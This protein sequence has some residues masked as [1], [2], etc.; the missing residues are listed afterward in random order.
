MIRRLD[1]QELGTVAALW[2]DTNLR[3][4]RFI[5]PSYWTGQFDSVRARL[6]EAEVYV[7]DRSSVIDGFIGLAGGYI[8]GLFVR[9]DAQGA[10][11]GRQLLEHAKSLRPRLT[12][13]VYAK[14]EGAIRFYLREGFTVCSA[15]TDAAT[16]Q[17]EYLMLWEAPSAGD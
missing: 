9:H 16:G 13:H 1:P 10:G 5:P 12:L 6:P 4:H 3:A 14:N 17:E 2:L 15:D 11:I 7:Y 8:A